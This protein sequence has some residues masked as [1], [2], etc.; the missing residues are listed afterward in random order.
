MDY[1]MGWGWGWGFGWIAMF[2]VWIIPVALLAAA[3]KYLFF[4]DAEIRRD[5]REP[6][7][8]RDRD[9]RALALL[10][11]RYARGDLPREEFLQKRDDIL[12]R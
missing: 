10:E 7:E 12:K 9:S 8:L 6:R 2:L 3:I 4:H 1:G 5:S 11:E